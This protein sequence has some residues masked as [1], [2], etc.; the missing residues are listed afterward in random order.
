MWELGTRGRTRQRGHGCLVDHCLR[1]L[2]RLE[3]L[4]ALLQ[5]LSDAWAWLESHGSLGPDPSQNAGWQ[6]V[7][8]RGRAAATS[9][10][11]LA[12]VTAE[13][14]LAKSV[15]DRLECRIRPIFGLGDYETSAFAALKE[16]EIR[17]CELAG[18]TNSSIGVNLMRQRSTGS[19]DGN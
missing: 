2:W 11:A 4:P 5:R 7:T 8:E 17:V 10:Q 6:R 12:E 14:R 18:A 3:D 13:D 16:V 15:H 1:E 19:L 9:A